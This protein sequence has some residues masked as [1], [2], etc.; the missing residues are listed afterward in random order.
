MSE[1]EHL[2]ERLRILE[3]LENIRRLKYKYFRCVDLKLWDELAECFAE[4]ARTSYADGKYQLQGLDA[5]LRF[6]KKGIG[7]DY[8]TAI[9]HGHHPEIDVLS[10]T[11]AKG[12]WAL[13]GYRI[14]N[15]EK[16]AYR[17]GAIYEDEYVKVNGEWKISVTGYT[18]IFEEIVKRPG[19]DAGQ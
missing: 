19:N 3:D 13:Y 11:M 17:H 4:D 6:L 14:D 15:R 7:P 16:T 10:N 12:K 5:I 2:E 9:H 1:I 8:V 18:N